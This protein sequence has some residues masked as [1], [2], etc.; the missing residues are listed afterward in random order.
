[1]TLLAVQTILTILPLNSGGN[2]SVGLENESIL[3]EDGDHD[4]DEEIGFFDGIIDWVLS[5]FQ[6]IT[7]G[8]ANGMEG[9]LDLAFGTPIV[10]TDG[11]LS[12]G[13][14]EAMTFGRL[15]T[16]EII[17]YG[18]YRT[19]E[20]A[21]LGEG[22]S[23][24]ILAIVIMAVGISLRGVFDMVSYSSNRGNES[25]SYIT[26]FIWIALWY[27]VFLGFVNVVHAVMATFAAPDGGLAYGMTGAIVNTLA[28]AY[29]ANIA[30]PLVIAVAMAPWVLLGALM[31][32]RGVLIVVLAAFG[33]ILIAG[34]HT[35]LPVISGVCSRFLNKTVPIVL[36][37]MPIAP[38]M[39]I[40]GNFIL[41]H[42]AMGQL[43]F[44]VGGVFFFGIGCLLLFA[45]WTTFKIVSPTMAST[46]GTLT[47][48]GAAIGVVAT[49][50][51]GALAYSA[52]RGGATAAAVRAAANKWGGSDGSR[53]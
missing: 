45:T 21:W 19:Y 42:P 29:V 41:A 4:P 28:A 37:P 35:N 33:P 39:F 40:L 32:V 31:F 18:F 50:G 12:F 6:T 30:A 15:F 23:I 24:A 51:S 11:P 38:I 44:L 10:E 9:L 46:G 5:R 3:E 2:G 22:G 47:N 53:R 36:L 13:E 14:P 43:Q 26:G 48:I 20:L 7:D 52:L 1:V 34:K 8:M 27:P 16:N 17:P 49:G 25:N